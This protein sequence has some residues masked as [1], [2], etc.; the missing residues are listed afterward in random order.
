MSSNPPSFVLTTSRYFLNMSGTLLPTKLPSHVPGIL[1]L[2]LELR[3]RILLDVL[4]AGVCSWMLYSDQLNGF[5]LHKDDPI[6]LGTQYRSLSPTTAGY[7]RIR[8]ILLS[9]K[10]LHE[11]CLHLLARNFT[12]IVHIDPRH[13]APSGVNAF[14]ELR[15]LRPS[16]RNQIRRLPILISIL[17]PGSTTFDYRKF[18]QMMSQDDDPLLFEKIVE[19]INEILDVM[20]A[21]EE[22]YLVWLMF[23]GNGGIAYSQQRYTRQLFQRLRKEWPGRQ[24]KWSGRACM[25]TFDET[26]DFKY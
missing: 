17:D 26:N 22:V 7:A 1:R 3:S 11:D 13:T 24:I 12:F 16:F 4:S 20:P 9:C 18:H 6:D 8:G 23:F 19:S 15:A 14:R 5:A 25:G 21:L 2:P 10:S